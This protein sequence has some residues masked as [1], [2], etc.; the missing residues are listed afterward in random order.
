MQQRIGPAV[1]AA[2]F[3]AL[4]GADLWQLI[5]AA[6]GTH[7]DPPSLLVTHGLTG[8]LAGAAAIGSWRRRRWAVLAVL[9]WG[10]VTAAML[11][12]LGPVLDTPAAERPQLRVAA[13]ATV[14]L[15]SAI[16]WYLHRA[17]RTRNGR[18]HP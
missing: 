8:L 4:C 16:A 11:L 18:A 12:A 14:G 3:T 17:T 15:A 10:V 1:C 9:G 7:P 13:A 2:L 6:R 5:E